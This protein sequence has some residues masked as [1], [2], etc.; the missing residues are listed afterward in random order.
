MVVPSDNR[1]LYAHR[2]RDRFG[3]LSPSYH[4]PFFLDDE[5]WSTIQH[6]YQAQKSSDPFYQQA[7][8]EAVTPDLAKRL[9]ASAY[10]P[11]HASE[12]SW[13]RRQGQSA[14]PDWDRIR[15]NVMR[16]AQMAKYTQYHE[17][18]VYLLATASAELVKDSSTNSYWGIGRDGRGSNWAGR[19]LMEVR[20]RLRRRNLH[21]CLG[22]AAIASDPGQ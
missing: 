22:C 6:Y 3:F 20:A 18:A 10:A 12:D 2:D 17:L 15:L 11:F 7:V 21:Q 14:R 9:G 16:R 19:V 8:R 1:I 13:F 5:L 4:A